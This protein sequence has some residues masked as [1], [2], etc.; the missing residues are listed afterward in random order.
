MGI[1]G[2]NHEDVQKRLCRD[3]GKIVR[4]NQ[5]AVQCDV[6]KLWSHVKCLGMGKWY[7]NDVVNWTCNWCSLPFNQLDDI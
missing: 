6:C 5:Y 7:E 3:S 4:K 2:S 1:P